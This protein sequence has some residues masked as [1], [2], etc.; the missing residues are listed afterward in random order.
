MIAFRASYTQTQSLLISEDPPRYFQDSDYDVHDDVGYGDGPSLR[1]HDKCLPFGVFSSSAFIFWML[2]D[3]ALLEPPTLP[4]SKSV[5][6]SGKTMI[7][8]F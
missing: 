5:H 2:N 7:P 1:D 8:S 3:F 4:A 6:T